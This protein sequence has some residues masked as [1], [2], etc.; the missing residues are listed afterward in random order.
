MVQ[1]AGWTPG[2][3]TDRNSWPEVRSTWKIKEEA[4]S[5][6]EH[7]LRLGDRLQT[8]HPQTAHQRLAAHPVQAKSGPCSDMHRHWAAILKGACK[9]RSSLSLNTMRMQKHSP[10]FYPHCIYP[11]GMMAK[12]FKNLTGSDIDQS[13]WSALLCPGLTFSLMDCGELREKSQGGGSGRC[14]GNSR[15]HLLTSCSRYISVFYQQ[16]QP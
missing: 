12:T 1:A 13:E 2:T 4:T 15:Q 5:A 8:R 9:A 14:L 11:T 3:R 7:C 6:R 10:S 16:G